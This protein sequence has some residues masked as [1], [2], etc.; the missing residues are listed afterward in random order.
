MTQSAELGRFLGTNRRQAQEP[1]SARPNWE[2]PSA[3]R[4]FRASSDDR[5]TKV[6]T[7]SRD[8]IRSTDST[9]ASRSRRTV[10]L[11]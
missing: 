5:D 6:L 3:I 10:A 1:P 2:A 4:R 11:S 8:A 9:L 7:V